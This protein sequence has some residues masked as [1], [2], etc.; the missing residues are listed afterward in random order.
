MNYD[1]NNSWQSV[2]GRGVFS[3]LRELANPLPFSILDLDNLQLWLKADS[4]V[5]ADGA[6]RFTAANSEYFT[7]SS[8]ADL[9]TGDIDFSVYGFFYLD[10]LAADQAIVGK[11]GAAAGDKEFLLWYSQATQDI[12]FNCYGTGGAAI[13]SP[14]AFT[15]VTSGIWYFFAA[16]HDATANTINL[17]VNA[18]SVASASTTDIPNS[19]SGAF[20]IGSDESGGI[21]TFDG[22]IAQVGFTKEVLASAERTWLYNNNSGRSYA[23]YGVSGTDGEFLKTNL[24]AFWP[25]NE[26]S[27]NAI[28]AHS[29]H[30]LTDTNSVTAVNG[31]I[32]TIARDF[33]ANDHYAR[34]TGFLAEQ[35]VTAWR[36]ETPTAYTNEYSLYFDGSDY[37]DITSNSDFDSVRSI[38]LWYRA[39]DLV[40]VQQLVSRGSNDFEVYMSGATMNCYFGGAYTTSD[41]IPTAEV[42]EHVVYTISGTNV[43]CYKN[44]VEVADKTATGTPTYANTGNVNL[45]RRLSSTQYFGGYMKDVRLYNDVITEEEALYLAT[46]GASGIDPGAANLVAGYLFNDGPQITAITDGDPVANW[47]SQDSQRRIFA[48]GTI[49]KRPVYNAS[50]S[51]LNNKPSITFDGVDD[52]LQGIAHYLSTDTAGTVYIV[53]RQQNLSTGAQALLAAGD[54]STANHWLMLNA[55]GGTSGTESQEIYYKNSATERDMHGSDTTVADANYILGFISDGSTYRMRLNGVEQTITPTTGTNDGSW[56]GDN[57]SLVNLSIGALL[58]D[59][60]ANFFDGEIAEIIAT[61]DELTADEAQDVEAYLSTKYGV[62]VYGV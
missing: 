33:S 32:I 13:A 14:V 16:W 29:T 19:G 12:F 8:H 58:R 18:G 1:H 41:Y 36:T 20:R 22:R 47:I 62:T 5:A 27:G 42:W 48:Q 3:E 54:G 15:N 57:S 2:F 59:S 44:G 6:R 4:S 35:Q 9:S 61:S 30:D 38:A 56:F 53:G 28:D 24:K 43:K 50:D 31:P 7:K 52:F 55:H 49:S 51:N 46:N 23:D 11:Y 37:C 25:L 26:P 39:D 40:G 34:L 60:N 45:G 17:Q 10:S 21:G